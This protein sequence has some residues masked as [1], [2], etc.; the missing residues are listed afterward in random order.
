MTHSQLMLLLFLIFYISLIPFAFLFFLG[1]N[2]AWWKGYYERMNMK[3]SNVG[4]ASSWEC[5][6]LAS[7]MYPIGIFIIISQCEWMRYGWTLWTLKYE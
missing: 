5:A 6:F 3:F 1:A 2:I 7:L 4:I